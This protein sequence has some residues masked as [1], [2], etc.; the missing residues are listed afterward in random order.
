LRT[1]PQPS[2]IFFFY[3]QVF[4]KMLENP[5]RIWNNGGDNTSSLFQPSE[6]FE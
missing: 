6:A 4:R 1:S 3:G 5:R 2:V